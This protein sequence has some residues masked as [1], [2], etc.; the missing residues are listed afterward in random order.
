[1]ASSAEVM[2]FWVL[3]YVEPQNFASF[4]PEH[5][6]PTCEKKFYPYVPYDPKSND[7]RAGGY[8]IKTLYNILSHNYAFFSTNLHL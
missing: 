7:L 6:Y 5:I 3:L 1:M 2:I 8:L 4:I